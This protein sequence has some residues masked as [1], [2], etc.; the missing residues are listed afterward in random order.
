MKY[1]LQA[2]NALLYG[3]FILYFIVG[4]I[5]SIFDVNVPDIIKTW[6]LIILGIGIITK[7]LRVI[8]SLPIFLLLAFSFLI[9]VDCLYEG[10]CVIVGIPVVR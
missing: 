7:R 2:I 10:I 5:L 4:E 3:A 1:I 8:I 9:G 6:V